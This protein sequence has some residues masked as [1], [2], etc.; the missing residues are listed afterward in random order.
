MN[1]YLTVLKKYA[2]FS[3]RARRT[4]YWMFVLINVLICLALMGLYF[5]TELGLFAVLY[6]LY[7]LAILI[8]MLAVTVRRLHDTG[9]SGWWYFIC[10]VPFVGGLILLVFTVLEGQSGPNEY[11]P[12][13]KAIS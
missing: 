5:V 2:E 9:R 7:S 6:S 11:G 10:F 12:D 3:G 1:W 13:P 4:E 8:P